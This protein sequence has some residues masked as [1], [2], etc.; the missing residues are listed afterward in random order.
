M[1]ISRLSKPD[2]Q[3]E[4]AGPLPYNT[5]GSWFRDKILLLLTQVSYCG[6]VSFTNSGFRARVIRDCDMAI[7]LLGPG[8]LTPLNLLVTSDT[9]LK[10]I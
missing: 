1:V 5:S 6:Y 2:S 7:V 9:F 3:D 4:Q 8:S 10:C